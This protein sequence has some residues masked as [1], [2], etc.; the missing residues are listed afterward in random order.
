[1]DTVSAVSFIL[2]SVCSQLL[3]QAEAGVAKR[4]LHVMQ[5]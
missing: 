4:L 1:M 5:A 2:G 3:K